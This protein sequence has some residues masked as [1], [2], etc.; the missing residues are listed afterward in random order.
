MTKQA[1]PPQTSILQPAPNPATK[2]AALFQ[3]TPFSKELHPLPPVHL[4]RDDTT[5]E[6]LPKTLMDMHEQ[7]RRATMASRQNPASAPCHARG[8]VFQ[9][10]SANAA[11]VTM[12]F[13]H[14]LGRPHTGLHVC[15]T[16]VTGA[17]TTGLSMPYE[18]PNPAGVVESQYVTVATMVPANTTITHDLL[19]W[20]D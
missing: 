11:V 10:Q 16:Q 6:R 19:L 12:T 14:A 4:T 20:G 1:R 3:S 13:R 15:R 5:G 7:F 17:P 9:N 18:V 2:A 8:I